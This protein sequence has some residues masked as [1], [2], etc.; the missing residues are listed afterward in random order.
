[1]KRV[2]RA[3]K[4]KAKSPNNEDIDHENKKNLDRCGSPTG[5]LHKAERNDLTLGQEIMPR[6][7]KPMQSARKIY[8]F[9]LV[10]TM[11]SSDW[12]FKIADTTFFF[13]FFLNSAFYVE[14]LTLEKAKRMHDISKNWVVK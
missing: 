9:S 13:F 12:S 5:F 11:G 3:S 4:I 7:I 10:P 6:M 8:I 2:K 1:M 14:K